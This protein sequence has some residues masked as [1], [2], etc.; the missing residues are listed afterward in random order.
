MTWKNDY[1]TLPTEQYE[2][3]VAETVAELQAE[4]ERLMEAF[5]NLADA[6]NELNKQLKEAW[7]DEIRGK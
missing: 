7:E 1:T 3:M 4:N 2:R 5:S 6:F